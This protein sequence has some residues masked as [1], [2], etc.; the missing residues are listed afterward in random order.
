MSDKSVSIYLLIY[1]NFLTKVLI[2]T[3][4]E[5]PDDRLSINK[6]VNK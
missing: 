1:R 6:L 5:L 3:A 2:N 4:N